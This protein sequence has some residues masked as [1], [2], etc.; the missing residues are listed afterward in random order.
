MRRTLAWA[1]FLLAVAVHLVV[2]YSPESG[3]A[4][5][6]PHADKVVHVVVFALV[7]GTGLLADVRPV[8]LLVALLAHAVVSEVLQAT[9]LTARTGSGWD[10]AADAL[11][12]VLGVLPGLLARRRGHAP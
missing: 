9:V 4:P 6:F 8:P 12:A 5:P 3:G 2:L 11:G 10:A 7:G 1:V